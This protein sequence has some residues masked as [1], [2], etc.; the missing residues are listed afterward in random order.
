MENYE[1]EF[2]SAGHRL[3]GILVS[4]ADTPSPVALLISGSGPID[5]DSNMKKQ[6]LNV[7]R[8]FAQHLAAAGIASYRYD[9]RGV[10]ASAGSYKATGLYDNIADAA[11]AV[12][13]L[14]RRPEI[15]P[16]RVYV[17]GHSEGAF[18]ASDLAR[19]G[20]LAGVVL[21]A[22]ATHTG[23]Q[24]MRWQAS[25]IAETI[26]RPVK[27]LLKLLRKDLLTVQDKR[28]TQL[29]ESQND[30]ERIQ[31]V[32][33]NAKWFREF[34]AFD[35]ARALSRV[36]VPVLAITGAKD[37]QVN[38]DD[39]AEMEEIVPTE[40]TGAVLPDVTHLLRRDDGPAGLKTYKKQMKRPVD[41]RLLE[42]VSGWV[43]DTVASKDGARG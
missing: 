30:V 17:I 8:D 1:I 19:S 15:D 33:I 23:E 40:F 16:G 25:Q 5:R 6:Q 4:P 32:K 10:G 37:V 11:A 38:P 12:D 18:I 29:K 43:K 36:R 39:I 24:V 3:A 35:P 14:R 13:M 22:G 34:L 28:L 9:K 2:T 41:R 7:M 27:L 42:I 20:D 26:P 21:L 31:L